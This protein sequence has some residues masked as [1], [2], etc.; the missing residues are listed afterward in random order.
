LMDCGYLQH[1]AQLGKSY[2]IM[3][4]VT[5]KNKVKWLMAAITGTEQ[6]TLNG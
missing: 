6:I 3:Q 5:N 1:C 2:V 4:I